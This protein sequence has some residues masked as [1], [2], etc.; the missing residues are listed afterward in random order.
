MDCVK[1]GSSLRANAKLCLNCGTPVGADT[2]TISVPPPETTLPGIVASSQAKSEPAPSP[3]PTPVSAPTPNPTPKSVPDNRAG[4][5]EASPLTAMASVAA[6]SDE[7]QVSAADGQQSKIAERLVVQSLS[8]AQ[9]GVAQGVAQLKRAL[10]IKVALAGSVFLAI[11]IAS[12]VG[13]LAYSQRQE[14]DRVRSDQAKADQIAKERDEEKRRG[15]DLQKKLAEA[16]ELARKAQEKVKLAE[17]QAKERAE[18][19]KSIERDKKEK[20]EAEAK[21]TAE[22]KALKDRQ[23]KQDTARR[24]GSQ[25]CTGSYSAAWSD[26]VGER[27]FP[28]G[29]KYIGAFKDGRP[30]GRGTIN[31]ISGA[32]YVGDWRNAQR[33]GRGTYTYPN[34][35]TYIGEWLDNQKSGQ[36]TYARRDGSKYVG[37]FRADNINGFGTSYAPDGTVVYAGQWIDNKPAQQQAQQKPISSTPAPT[38]ATAPVQASRSPQEICADRPNFISRGICERRECENN[39]AHKGNAY[40][41]KLKESQN[42]FPGT[43]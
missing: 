42:Q 37:E 5:E 29:D 34:G 27:V 12:G 14:A 40:C 15:E 6:K 32:S 35:A 19:E 9:V 13:Y 17:D 8:F 10:F 41:E 31:W 22:A 24:G 28:N 11:V 23:P 26:C 16:E 39:P 33:H 30:H 4:P 38:P 2:S 25:P 36:G 21:A 20:A 43:N 3:A 1:C 7:C 18:Q